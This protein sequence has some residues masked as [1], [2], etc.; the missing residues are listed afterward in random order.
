MT[1]HTL[2][3]PQAPIVVQKVRVSGGSRPASGMACCSGAPD[4]SGIRLRVVSHSPTLAFPQIGDQSESDFFFTTRPLIRAIR[5]VKR[6]D[7]T[8]IEERPRTQF[9]LTIAKSV[10]SSTPIGVLAR[11]GLCLPSFQSVCPVATAGYLC[12]VNRIARVMHLPGRCF[13]YRQVP[14]IA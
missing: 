5:E 14:T 12:I 2:C 8:L 4:R 7:L 9:S 6:W 10:D 3:H 1:D 11:P 13:D